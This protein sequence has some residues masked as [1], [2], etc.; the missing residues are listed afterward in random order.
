MKIFLF[1]LIF[2]SSLS[3]G[4]TFKNGE[5]TEDD[6]PNSYEKSNNSQIDG[7]YLLKWETLF[8]SDDKKTIIDSEPDAIDEVNFVNGKVKS[9]TFNDGVFIGNKYRKS[10]KIRLK[11]DDIIITGNLDIDCDCPE[12]VKIILKMKKMI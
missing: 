8:F 6:T 12:K 10:T 3:W 1:I 4:L 7:A 2:F 5:Q 9:I 11:K